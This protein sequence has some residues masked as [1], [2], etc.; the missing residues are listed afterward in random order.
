M[1]ENFGPELE[2]SYFVSTN[3]TTK[4]ENWTET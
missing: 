2:A 3:I 4:N 1:L